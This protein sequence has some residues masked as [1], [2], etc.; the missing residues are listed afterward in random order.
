VSLLRKCLAAWEQGNISAL[1][2]LCG[3]SDVFQVFKKYVERRPVH[4][5]AANASDLAIIKSVV[6]DHA[7]ELLIKDALGHTVLDWVKV[8][9]HPAVV[10]F[11]TELDLRAI[12]CPV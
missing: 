8:N 9:P 3:E 1:I 10:S 6:R 5:A 11:F 7:P 2:D 4:F 12:Q